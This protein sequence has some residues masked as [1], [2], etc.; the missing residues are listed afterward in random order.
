[1]LN[2]GEDFL[3]VNTTNNIKKGNMTVIIQ[4]VNPDKCGGYKNFNVKIAPKTMEKSPIVNAV[5]SLMNL[6]K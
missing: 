1:M 5:K 2:Y 4:G 3:V 6:F